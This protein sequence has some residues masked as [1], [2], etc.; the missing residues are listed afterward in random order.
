MTKPLSVKMA[1]STFL[2]WIANHHIVQ[3][4]FAN[5]T[6]VSWDSGEVG[7][8]LS[9]REHSLDSLDTENDFSTSE[10]GALPLRSQCSMS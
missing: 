4:L 5:Y 2:F 3:V 9:P 7:T 1:S 6:S 10:T 8:G